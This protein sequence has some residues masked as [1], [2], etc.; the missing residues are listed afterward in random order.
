MLR[1]KNFGRKSLNELKELLE[2]MGLAFGMDIRGWTP[3]E[4]DASKDDSQE[5]P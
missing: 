1:T 2:A 5:I 4:A 3:A